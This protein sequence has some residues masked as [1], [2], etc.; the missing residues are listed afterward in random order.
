MIDR[1]ILAYFVLSHEKG[2]V[3]RIC[4]PLVRIDIGLYFHYPGTTE[5]TLHLGFGEGRSGDQRWVYWRANRTF[6]V[7]DR[8]VFEDWICK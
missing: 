1:L 2:C 8:G 7:K 3:L 5:T 6:I 4:L